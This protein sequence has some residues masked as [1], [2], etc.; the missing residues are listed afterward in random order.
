MGTK[1]YKALIR[2][3]GPLHIGDG[4][5]LGNKDYFQAGNQIAVLDMTRFI[6][7]LN[8]EQLKAY[9]DFLN[10]DSRDGLEKFLKQN[11][12]HKHALDTAA[13]RVQSNLARARRGSIQYFPVFSFIKDAHGMPYVP[14]SSLKGALRN[15]LLTSIIL[16]SPKDYYQL[17]RSRCAEKTRR[18]NSRAAGPIEK[19]AFWIE[20]PIPKDTS[21]VNDILKYVS[22]SDSRPLQTKNLVFVKKYDKFSKG[23]PADHKM[24]MGNIS[25]EERFKAGNELNIYRECLSAGTEI[26]FD[27]SIDDRILKYINLDREGLLKILKLTY[28]FQNDYFLSNFDMKVN[29]SS[30]KVGSA[31]TARIACG[32]IYETGP[33]KGMPC[34]NQAFGDTGFCN[35]HRDKIRAEASNGSSSDDA[36]KVT[37]FLGGGVGYVSKTV[38]AAIIENDVERLEEISRILFEQFPTWL[39]QTK[40]AALK[41]RIVESGFSPNIRKAQYRQNGR[42]KKAKEDHRHWRDV[43][44]GVSPHTI[45]YG[46]VGG[47]EQLMGKCSL[48]ISEV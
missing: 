18:K 41:K 2:T 14:G 7:G 1:N 35:T 6:D 31:N 8:D 45:K 27:L 9:I 17:Y 28:D 39:D 10:T 11:N 36:S 33:L 15:A 47:K 37:L 5:K 46:I 24:K 13:Y 3:E 34:R 4:Q 23:D 40:H 30:S 26:E 20:A 29:S 12:L 48:S 32:Y 43:E 16:D 42:L 38:T 21:V 25:K 44:L 22:V 19:K